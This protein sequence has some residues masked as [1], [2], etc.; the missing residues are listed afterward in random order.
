MKKLIIV[1]VIMISAV[2]VKAQIIYEHTY[3][4]PQSPSEAR[5]VVIN[6]GGSDGYKYLYVDY[7]T[8]QLRLFNLDHSNFA[9]VTVPTLLTNNSEYRI[10]YVTWSLFDCDTTMFEYA[11][12]PS[13]WKNTFCIYRQDGSVVFKKDSTLAIWCVGCY[14][15]SYEQLPIYNTPVGAKLLLSKSDSLGFSKTID[16]YS[17]CGSLPTNV[18]LTNAGS[19]SHLKVFPNPTDM[20]VNFEVTPTN[21]FE[22]LELVVFDITGQE[23]RRE[24]VGQGYRL[25]TLDVSYLPSGTYPFSLYSNG[26]KLDSGKF[27]ISK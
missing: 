21:N 17:L 14:D 1:V 25:Y 18:S 13:I 5:P 7:Q 20:T 4:G 23:I 12:L 22:K 11:V 16:V 27:I 8:N 24:T 3:P 6:M 9:T 19:T 2:S 15:R 26:Q 10:G